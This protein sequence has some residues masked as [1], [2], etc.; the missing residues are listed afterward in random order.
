MKTRR[1]LEVDIARLAPLARD[2]QR[3][4]MRRL[5]KGGGR[6]SLNPTR[7]QFPDIMNVQPP[8]FVSL[9]AQKFTDFAVVEACLRRACR[10]GEELA[11]NLQAS[12]M[13]HSHYCAQGIVSHE[14]DFGSMSLG[15]DRGIRFWVPS[16]YGRGDLPVITFI[17]PRGGQR[18]TALGRDVVF[19][20]MHASIRERNPD[21]SEAVLEIIQLPYDRKP[22]SSANVASTKTLQVFTLADQPKYDFAQIDGMLTDTLRL[23]D[24]VCSEVAEEIRREATGTGPLI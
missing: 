1:L 12:R 6:F 5:T 13:L 16:Y 2:E 9:G 3:I 11:F 20:A 17:D 7:D 24:E 15:L 8:M 14:Y 23:W 18:L 4:R 19:S 22:K 10:S 21:F